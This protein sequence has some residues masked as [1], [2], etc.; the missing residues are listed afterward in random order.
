[1]KRLTCLFTI[2]ITIVAGSCRRTAVDPAHPLIGKWKVTANF[3]SPGGPGTWINVAKGSN[4]FVEFTA[5]GGIKG[6]VFPA[7]STYTYKD[8]TTLT[9]TGAAVN[10]ENYFYKMNHDTLTMGPAGPIYCIESCAIRFIR[11]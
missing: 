9:F 1:M 5:G 7:Y 2:V 3:I 4:S 11:E 6:N 10:A 8:S